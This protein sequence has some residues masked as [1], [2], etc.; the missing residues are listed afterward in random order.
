[1][2]PAATQSYGALFLV[3]GV[4]GLATV[5]TMPGAVDAALGG[6]S[7]LTVGRMERYTHALAGVT[8][9]LCG[10]AIQFLGL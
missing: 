10:V 3:T 5:A 8:I 6:I 7:R 9:L 1:M 2:F 4:F